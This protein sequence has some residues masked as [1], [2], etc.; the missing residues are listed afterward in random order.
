MYPLDG[1]AI[2]QMGQT[3]NSIY[4]PALLIRA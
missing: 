4:W 3:Q 2:L 1:H